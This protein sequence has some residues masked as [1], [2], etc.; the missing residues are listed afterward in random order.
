MKI[1]WPAFSNKFRA[2]KKDTEKLVNDEVDIRRRAWLYKRKQ[3]AEAGRKSAQI[4]GTRKPKT[5]NDSANHRSTYVNGH[6]TFPDLISRKEERKDECRANDSEGSV[7]NHPN[8]WFSRLYARHPKK[9]HK[10]LAYEAIRRLWESSSDPQALFERIDRVH[11]YLC[12]TP[13]WKKNN[14]SFAPKLD[15]WI[16]DEGYEVTGEHVDGPELPKLQ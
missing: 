3:S 11:A 1:V 5:E 12:S 13:D 15:E 7:P 4:R 8:Y 2:H 9:K 14:G 16:A 10:S 6:S